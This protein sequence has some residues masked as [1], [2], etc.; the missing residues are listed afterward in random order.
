MLLSNATSLIHA[1]IINYDYFMKS[2]SVNVN[3]AFNIKNLNQDNLN[4]RCRLQIVRNNFYFKKLC[5]IIYWIV[6]TLSC[7]PSCVIP[8]SL[9]K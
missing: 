3:L 9:E 4:I 1:T 8:Y 2:K 6:V 5:V 7:Y